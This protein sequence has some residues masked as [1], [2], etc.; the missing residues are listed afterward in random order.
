MA[1]A[2]RYRLLSV[3]GQG[4]FGTVYR[5]RL[6]GEEGFSKPVALKVL[7]PE[8]AV[9]KELARRL[10]DE[11]RV[12]GLV[13]HRAIVKVDAL[14]QLDGR[15]TV[16]MEYVE[17]RDLKTILE[18]GPIPVGAAL[19]IAAEVSGALHAAYNAVGPDD[20]PLHLLHRDIKPANICVTALGEVKV[21]DFGIARAEFG[22][23]EAKTQSQ[24]YGTPDYMAP[25][26]F[27]YEN[28]PEAD[29][30]AVG[31]TLYEMLLGQQLGRASPK[32]RVHNELIQGRLGELADALGP[33][34]EDVIALL[35]EMLDAEPARRPSARDAERRLTRLRHG[36]SGLL[37]RDW[38]ESTLPALVA[39]QE[40]RVDGATGTLLVEGSSAG[41]DTS[42]PRDAW[43]GPAPASADS[44]T[45]ALPVVVERGGTLV[46]PEEADV[47]SA[48][49][50][51]PPKPLPAPPPPGGR[52][53]A[54]LLGGGIAVF[55]AFAV[56][57][58]RPTPEA[59]PP[60]PADPPATTRPTVEPPVEVAPPP[61]EAA[62][63]EASPTP[64]ATSPAR[65]SAPAPNRPSA[66][67][68]T[69]AASEPTA[70]TSQTAATAAGPAGTWEDSLNGR[71]MD[72]VLRGSDASLSGEVKVSFGANTVSSRVRGRW[73]AE[74]RTLQ[75]EDVEQTE[76]A[77]TYTAT[78]DEAGTR[79]SGTF[80]AA[81]GG[82][83]ARFSASRG[84]S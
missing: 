33:A 63:P 38:A 5:A 70:T 17:G 2:R 69:P 51:D 30:Y 24:A 57:I 66:A 80:R 65:A 54:L 35:R 26:R 62:P 77:G 22:D 61:V 37:L 25:E 72:L 82:T 15:W 59:A 20:T 49:T 75:L 4:G 18:S 40:T 84:G 29:L 11:A 44:A 53:R 39:A 13:Q 64:P 52:R 8:L 78:L 43:P 76:D 16:V 23:R 68:P 6:L 28:G 12:L 58:S 34:H 83:I 3:L 14:V 47:H 19:E 1:Q 73:D 27:L 50:L 48:P 55:A 10:R 67:T 45:F 74:S 60:A 41:P 7:N 81:A 9:V 31:A 46:A 21:L 42:A 79:L 32:D 36:K 71:P 56:L